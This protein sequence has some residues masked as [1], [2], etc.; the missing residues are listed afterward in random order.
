[1]TNVE[2]Q[3]DEILVLQSIFDKKFHFLD[4]NQY[5][6]SIEFD[7][8]IPITIRFDN[9]SSIIQ[10]L[11]PF[12]LI[13]QYHDEYPSEYP[14]SFIVS[15]FYFSKLNLQKLC[16]KLDNY[17]FNNGDVCVYD[18][19][20]L[21]KLEINNEMIFHT[22]AEEEEDEEENDPRALN[23]YLMEAGE[24]LFQYLIN[25]NQQRENEQFQNQLQ[26]C[27]ICT[28][29]IRGLDCI[30]L[31]RC[32]HFYCRSCLNN[33]VR[34]TLDNGKFGEK[35]LC[36]QDQCKQP[37]LPTEVKQIIQDE[38]LYEKYER[39]TL[40]HSLELM[41]DIIFCPRCQYTVFID[42]SAD[43]LAMC[44]QCRYAFCK[45][46]K[47]NFHSQTACP[48]Q[49]M[50]EQLKLSEEIQRKRIKTQKQESRVLLGE[51]EERKNSSKSDK[52]SRLAKNLLYEQTTFEDILSAGRIDTLNTQPCPRCHIRIE[53]NGG[54]SH[55][56]C[57]RCDHHF[58]WQAVPDTSNPNNISLLDNY[59]NSAMRIPS[60]KKAL[61]KVTNTA[62]SSKQE[63]TQNKDID[64]GEK[65]D[66]QKVS[67]N[68][69]LDAHSV[70]VNRVKQCPSKSCKKFNMKM[71]ADNWMICSRCMKQYCFICGSVVHGKIHFAKKCKRQTPI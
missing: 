66:D 54:C 35:L 29:D 7:L 32:R 2:K 47:N 23:G 3:S 53:K 30:R 9:Q 68:N 40:Q 58:T 13:I 14:P 48:N 61:N 45:I 37:L 24:K 56:H 16:Q 65:E 19:I 39:L 64:S 36:P 1:M 55:M 52:H 21:I 69:R 22:G 42:D 43:N 33:Y 46:C 4:E 11:P 51:T 10:Y 5:E 63:T 26:T 71:S 50:I 12:N 70:I 34:R 20:D 41:D 28:D 18:W 25:Y 57:T 31:Q 62:Y 38:Q 27:L 6:I 59:M 44:E 8:N 60:V 49:W 17:P 15:C 67:G